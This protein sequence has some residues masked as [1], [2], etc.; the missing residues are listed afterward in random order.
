MGNCVES[1]GEVEKENVGLFV[2]YCSW[3][4][5]SHELPPRAAFDRRVLFGIHPGDAG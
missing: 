4:K 2:C 3:R 5:P 1:F